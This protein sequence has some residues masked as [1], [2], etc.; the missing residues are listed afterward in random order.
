MSLF[1]L[2]KICD[3]IASNTL[4]DLWKMEEERLKLPLFLQWFIDAFRFKPPYPIHY[5]WSFFAFWII[6]VIYEFVMVDL[7]GVAAVLVLLLIVMTHEHAHA[8][9]C[10]RNGAEIVSIEVNA[11]GLAVAADIKNPSDAV[12]FFAA[13]IKDTATYACSFSFLFAFLLF[14]GRDLVNGY[15]FILYPLRNFVGNIALFAVILVITNILP[16]WW[17]IKRYNAWV[18]SDGMAILKYREIRDELWNDGKVLAV[19][20]VPDEKYFNLH[21]HTHIVTEK[22]NCHQG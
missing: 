22:L 16:I 15:M 12:T 14:A 18:V 9:E 5:H 7:L 19:S 13:G 4:F 8:V 20:Y 3:T 10:L 1:V 21:T 11:L 6:L 17:Y 2:W